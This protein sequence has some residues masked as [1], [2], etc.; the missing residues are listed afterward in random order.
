MPI[1]NMSDLIC[2]LRAPG[3]P[4]K[5]IEVLGYVAVPLVFDADGNIVDE[6]VKLEKKPQGRSKRVIVFKCPDCGDEYTVEEE[7]GDWH[8]FGDGD[9]LNLT[10]VCGKYFKKTSRIP[11]SAI[12]DSWFESLES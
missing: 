8:D 2:T 9:S 3:L 4:D 1:L 11:D 7:F 12:I 10:C 6:P 5:G